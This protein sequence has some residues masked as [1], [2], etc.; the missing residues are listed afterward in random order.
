MNKRIICI[1]LSA[2]VMLVLTG[3]MG[4]KPEPAPEPL[5]T[6]TPTPEPTSEPIPVPTLEPTLE[7]THVPTPEPTSEPTPEPTIEPEPSAP[8]PEIYK[9]P[10]REKQLP[11]QTAIFIAEADPYDEAGWRAIAPNGQDVSLEAFQNV[12]PSCSVLGIYSDTLTITNVSLDMNGW[13]FY[14]VFVNEGTRTNT[15][16]AVLYVLLPGQSFEG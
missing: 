16:A 10:I 15:E 14:C 6:V 8:A 7:P 12:F 13:S 1:V 5:P 11:G 3:C 2:L 4:S 9:N